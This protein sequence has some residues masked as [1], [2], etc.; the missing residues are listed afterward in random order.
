MALAATLNMY[1]EHY[2]FDPNTLVLA[3]DDALFPTS[4]SKVLILIQFAPHIA[5]SDRQPAFHT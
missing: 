4:L 2:Q 1:A 5:S 3:E